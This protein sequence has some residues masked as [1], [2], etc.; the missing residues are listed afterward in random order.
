MT[1]S[2][3]YL[4]IVHDRLHPIVAEEYL[5][6]YESLP[7]TATVSDRTIV[8][9]PEI[10]LDSDQDQRHHRVRPDGARVGRA[11]RAFRQGA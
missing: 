3:R 6:L 8:T 9:S 7:E 4:R 11:R 2:Q 5:K 10:I 1:R